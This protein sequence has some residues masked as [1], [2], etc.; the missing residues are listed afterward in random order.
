MIDVDVTWIYYS[1][2]VFVVDVVVVNKP[3]Q[4]IML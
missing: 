4:Y 1:H 3:V 2:I